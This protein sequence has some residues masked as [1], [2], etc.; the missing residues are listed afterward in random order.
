MQQPHLTTHSKAEVL[1]LG[2]V[3]VATHH[4]IPTW[5][6]YRILPGQKIFESYGSNVY[7]NVYYAV[8]ALMP[9]LLCLGSA[10]RSGL[11]IGSWKGHTWRV[12][13]ICTVPVAV[14][15]AFYP[16]S[17]QHW[18]GGPVG[19]WLISPVA[20]D[21]LFAA[22]LFGLLAET[23]PGRVHPRLPLTKAALLTATLFA[24]WHTQ[25][26]E[27][28]SPV[29][30]LYQMSITFLFLAWTLFARQ[31]TGSVLPVILTHM[32]ANFVAWRGW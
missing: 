4:A 6:M 12:I 3:L 31:M 27:S 16:F 29:Y 21:L 9:L 28:L 5:L 11:R 8:S 18:T 23:F 20:Q 7:T 19:A 1:L 14:N 17:P 30:V 13:G 32:A 2:L 15:A 26:L 10:R 24:L 25:N 22:Y